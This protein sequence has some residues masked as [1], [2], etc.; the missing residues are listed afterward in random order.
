MKAISQRYAWV[1]V[2]VSARMR[3]QAYKWTASSKTL[4]LQSPETHLPEMRRASSGR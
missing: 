3:L 4:A 1:S 2:R